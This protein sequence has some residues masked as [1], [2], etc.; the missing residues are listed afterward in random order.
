MKMNPAARPLAAIVAA[1]ALFAAVQTADAATL[2]FG[3]LP[4]AAIMNPA[5]SATTGTVYENVTGS[6]S[7]R[8][9]P[10]ESAGSS[11]DHNAVDAWYTSVS[12]GATA[13]YNVGLSSAASF[14]WG[15]PDTYNTLEFLLG[16][17]VVDTV[18]LGTTYTGPVNPASFGVN[19]ALVTFTDITGGTF[20]AIKFSSSSNAFEFANLEVAPV[21]LPA[22]G[23]MLLAGLSG[24]A[25]V[26]RRK[27]AA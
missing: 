23:L 5:A 1:A 25:A 21:P 11:V 18:I 19:S 3:T 14:V 20:D 6:Q 2:S 15:S 13:T 12:G 17:A 26:R 9:S 4:S 22:A 7:D 10:W 16:G 27:T 8:R 24:F